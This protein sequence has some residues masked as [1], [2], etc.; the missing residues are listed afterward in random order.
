MKRITNIMAALLLLTACQSIG[1][2][3]SVNEVPSI[4]PD[5]VEVTV[6]STIAPLNFCMADEDYDQMYVIAT[7]PDGRKL[8]VNGKFAQFPMRKWHSFISQCGGGVVDMYVCARK[9]GVWTRFKNFNIY[10]S[11][12]AI[13]F[14]LTYRLIGPGY[15]NYTLMGIYQRDLS[16]FKE[17]PLLENTQF[18]GCVNCHSFNQCNP[19]DFSLHIRGDHGATLLS[20]DGDVEAY[21][22]K[23]DGSVGFCVYPYW[24]PSGDYIA[25]SSNAT[26]QTFHVGSQKLVE[27]FDTASDVYVYDVKNNELIRYP[28]LSGDSAWETFPS[29]SP[30]G[31]TLYFCKACPVDLPIGIRDV[32]Y[33]LCKVSFDPSTGKISGDVEVVV[34]AA[35]NGKS[36]SFPRPSFDGKYVMYTLSDYGN[37][38]IWH[39]ESDLW[40][41]EVATGECRPLLAAN[42]S[43]ADSYH[44]WS[45]NSH[46]FVIGS[47][48]LDNAFTRPYISHIDS[49]GI[50]TKPFLLPQ[51]NPREY[52]RSQ[53]RSYN[54]P[55]FV[56]GPVKLNRAKAERIINSSERTPFAS[57]ISD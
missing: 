15:H 12:D 6:P 42:S 43:L 48:R 47:R 50:S 13:D 56:T 45:S 5:Y 22:T 26:Q 36:V 29:F 24:H 17:T 4:F 52:Y 57:R 14:G 53:M 34:D 54:I 25:Y 27:V 31:K 20:I 18:K 10:V 3:V 8:K 9:D 38:S 16:T 11:D 44:N 49:R 40:L 1:E 19:S 30:D 39:A 28:E 41:Y 7:A 33:D 32:H 21:N 55:E 37:F 46:W 51:K 35:G 23:V 2:V